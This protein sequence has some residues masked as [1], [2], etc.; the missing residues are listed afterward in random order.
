MQ[1]FCATYFIFNDSGQLCPDPNAAAL[2]SGRNTLPDSDGRFLEYATHRRETQSL[3][4]SVL[5]NLTHRVRYRMT[6]VLHHRSTSQDRSRLSRLSETASIRSLF[7]P[8]ASP[9]VC[10]YRGEGHCP[11]PCSIPVGCAELVT[12]V[13]LHRHPHPIIQQNVPQHNTARKDLR[14]HKFH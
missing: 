10:P 8:L 5:S 2:S 9:G 6:R 1:F 12:C 7:T 4:P 11:R 14:E 3:S 13:P